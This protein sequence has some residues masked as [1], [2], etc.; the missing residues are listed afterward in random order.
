[1]KK[2]LA[3]IIA[4]VMLLSLLPVYA[5]DEVDL[6][7]TVSTPTI[8]AANVENGVKITLKSAT[9]NTE[10]YYTLDGTTPTVND[11]LYSA[12]FVID[13]AGTYNIRAIAYKNGSY[14]GIGSS[15]K[16]V[17]DCGYD[18][19]SANKVMKTTYSSSKKMYAVEFI[20]TTGY[21]VHYTVGYD[22]VTVNSANPANTP[23]Y[24]DRPSI[25][26]VL[27]CKTGYAPAKAS[28]LIS[29]SEW[30]GKDAVEDPVLSSKS[31]Y[32]GRD[33]YIS[34]AT[35]GADIYYITSTDLSDISEVK[36]TQTNG[37]LYT[38]PISFKTAGVHYI[39]VYAAKEG[40]FD[41]YQI[42][43]S[44]TVNKCA[45]PTISVETDSTNSSRKV[46]TIESSDG[47]EIYYTLTGTT[48]D[49]NSIRYTAPITLGTNRTVKAIAAKA[50]AVSSSVM[51]KSVTASGGDPVA[52]PSIERL[53]TTSNGVV[54][55]GIT[56]TTPD[57]QIYYI[58]V[59]SKNDVRKV[60]NADILYTDP[61]VLSQTGLYYICAVAYNDG[62]YSSTT[63]AGL[64][65]TVTD[66]P[67]DPY[68]SAET[69]AN[70]VKIVK[71]DVPEG[72]KV[73]YKLSDEDEENPSV[74]TTDENLYTYPLTI[75]KTQ[76]YT[77]VLVTDQGEKS[78]TVHGSISIENG[79]ATPDEV[80][81]ISMQSS[82][83]DGKVSVVLDCADTNADLFYVFD[84]NES[85]VAG[86]RSTAYTKGSAIEISTT[87][88]LHVVAARPGYEYRY[89]T[90]Y[91]TPDLEKTAAPTVQKFKNDNGNYVIV[92]SCDT[93]NVM[94]YYTTDGTTPT[95]GSNV[96]VSGMVAVTG[97]VTFKV[98]AVAD[99]YA[100]S[101]VVTEVLVEALEKCS[102]VIP[103]E[104]N[105]IGG[106]LISLASLTQ[107]ATIYYTTNGTDPT[108]N[109]LVYDENNPISVTYAGTTEIRA[110]AVKSG[111]D[112]SDILSYPVTLT[113]LTKPTGASAQLGDTIY[114]RLTSEDNAD[115]YYTTDGTIP[116]SASAKYE[117]Y[118]TS[119]TDVMIIAV[120]MKPGYVSSDAYGS[121]FKVELNAV[122]APT[123][124][125]ITMQSVL[126]GK[127][128]TITCATEGADI[129][130]SLED[131]E[132]GAITP[133]TLYT[134]PIMLDKEHNVI[135]LEAKKNG[136]ADSGKV[137]YKYAIGKAPVPVASVAT[138]S[139]VAAGSTVE[140]SAPHFTGLYGNED[141]ECI[142]FYTTDG[143][144]PTINSTEYTSP[145][146]IGGETR[147]RAISAAVGA[148]S[149]DI[150]ELYYTVEGEEAGI[151][152]NTD[153]LS[154]S[155]GVVYG[156]VN[157]ELNDVSGNGCKIVAAIYSGDRMLQALSAEGTESSQVE[158]DGFDILL[159]NS[160]GLVIKVFVLEEDG[161]TP[162]CKNAVKTLNFN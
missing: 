88:Y 159:E 139:V 29:V 70:G 65:V 141:T 160:G 46:V 149:S 113:K 19:S 97:G 155:N 78:N 85:T 107:G 18:V 43:R 20:N 74:D 54:T 64:E 50:G 28:F 69:L 83:S 104:Q 116:N 32:G 121:N 57:A 5:R 8:T 82:A 93:P 101:D 2:I 133:N 130:Y 138:N 41:S 150:L 16:T 90:Y 152:V 55:V 105:V 129:Y 146:E 30:A 63:A 77:A 38:G 137:Q 111:M 66:A 73:Y 161:I 76:F 49:E 42:I 94:Y 142:I 24:I 12:P 33:I 108:E 62:E 80:G 126:G 67:A 98:I 40:Y 1:M 4:T 109:S 35:E 56:T 72:C 151:T 117:G 135:T 14:S 75:T 96:A 124:D 36:V 10:I 68:P 119:K 17:Y 9:S 79:S 120:A 86:V 87:G 136:M 44:V 153:G 140:L 115:I 89:E 145:I 31:F 58:I 128:V 34:T 131:G 7:A 60:T 51:S 110:M 15:N 134:E 102:S 47:S 25:I 92:L 45:N 125:D 95:T 3:I 114:I 81:S 22:A 147:I 158:L 52:I 100:P 162:I 156:S 99:G 39:K 122:E 132:I 26:N 13:E 157:V 61:I 27:V 71:F 48:P 112:N 23:L 6:M 53:S 103:E 37:T 148:V 21:T 144:T 154:L 59:N 106:K 11:T 84:Q 143:S 123:K 91:I 127:L 118:I